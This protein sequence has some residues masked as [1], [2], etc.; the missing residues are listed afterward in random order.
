MT[1]WG[2]GV[3]AK[4]SVVN[5]IHRIEMIS[6]IKLVSCHSVFPAAA[7]ADKASFCWII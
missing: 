5:A 6:F 4:F 7:H 3:L 2:G 1:F